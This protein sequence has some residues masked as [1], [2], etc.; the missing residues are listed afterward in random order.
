MLNVSDQAKTVLCESE[1]QKD[2]NET[3]SEV[4]NSDERKEENNSNV[5]HGERRNTEN[6]SQELVENENPNE[7]NSVTE[8]CTMKHS[9]KVDDEEMEVEDSKTSESKTS[10]S[11]V[12][13][14]QKSLLDNETKFEGLSVQS[15][16]EME[17]KKDAEKESKQSENL[18]YTDKDVANF[19]NGDD[20]HEIADITDEIKTGVTQKVERENCEIKKESSEVLSVR[21]TENSSSDKIICTEELESK[22]DEDQTYKKTEELKFDPSER[23]E[24]I[25]GESE[26]VTKQE[27]QTDLN[28]ILK[29][30]KKE[31][32]ALEDKYDFGDTKLDEIKSEPVCEEKQVEGDRE[33][34]E[35]KDEMD[36]E[37][38]DEQ[39]DGDKEIKHE[40]GDGDKEMKEE[41]NEGDK[42]MKEEQ[43]EE[44]KEM[45]EEQ[46][47]GDKDKKEKQGKVHEEMKEEQN[48]GDD[49]VK[50]EQG[51]DGK[52]M[53]EEEDEDDKE[54][55]EK[56]ITASGPKTTLGKQKMF[57]STGP[58]V[59]PEPS[60]SNTRWHL[61][62]ST[63]DDWVNLAEW[64][65]DSQSRCEKMLMKLIK[66]D[67][68]PVL[69]EIIEARVSETIMYLL[70]HRYFFPSYFLTLSQ[71][72]P[73]FYMS[74][75]L[76]FWKH[77]GKR[78][79]IARKEH[80]LSSTV[81]K[82]MH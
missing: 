61:I 60:K 30:V 29:D 21:P 9:N 40:Q 80:F 35:E 72:I 4:E 59:P 19:Q 57:A 73:G 26:N 75:E 51:E 16:S 78:I 43:N 45:K 38:K 55:I 24:T 6:K 22:P 7:P 71:T 15:D 70:M 5:D 20:N 49:E 46:N 28:N 68:L 67:F 64:F 77:C 31:D 36:K 74:A 62:C 2:E 32:S 10:E 48:E 11:I 42:E 63:L 25:K 1:T 58:V 41:Q 76:V 18:K 3:C 27:Q 23:K 54:I 13:N 56:E 82:I 52:G 44:D 65:S 53:K 47:E 50:E 8:S 14:D 37:I 79:K 81:L 12:I 66:D 39:D 33:M 34:K 17:D 69:P